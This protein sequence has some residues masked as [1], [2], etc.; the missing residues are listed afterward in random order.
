LLSDPHR[1]SLRDAPPCGASHI[2]VTYFGL[3]REPLGPRKSTPNMPEARRHAARG[4]EGVT[5]RATPSKS[6]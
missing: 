5:T 2:L 4:A 3:Y 1:M 6:K